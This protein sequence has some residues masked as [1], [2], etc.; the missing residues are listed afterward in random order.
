MFIYFLILLKTWSPTVPNSSTI[1]PLQTGYVDDFG[2]TDRFFSV[3]TFGLDLSIS[4]PRHFQTLTK[5]NAP[6]QMPPNQ[7][8][9]FLDDNYNFIPEKKINFEYNKYITFSPDSMFISPLDISVMK[10]VNINLMNTGTSP[11]R[12]NN[13]WSISKE[14]FIPLYNKITLNEKQATLIPIYICPSS[15]GVFSTLI[16]FNTNK[17]T[18]PYF[19]QYNAVNSNSDTTQK[20]L[21]FQATGFEENV[22]FKIPQ[23]E[24]QVT[25]LYDSFLFNEMRS[26]VN[27]RFVQLS[28][29]KNRVGYYTSFVNVM[30]ENFQRTY[31]FSLVVSQKLLVPVKP[32]LFIETVTAKNESK[33]YEIKI[34]NPTS[35]LIEITSIQPPRRMPDNVK[36]IDYQLPIRCEIHSYTTIGKVIIDG[37]IEGEV[38]TNV[39]L[40][41]MLS[42]AS[43]QSLSIPIRGLVQY[44]RLRPSQEKIQMINKNGKNFEFN[45]TNEFKVPIGILGAR[46]SNPN[47]VVT[48]FAPFALSPGQTSHQLIISKTVI[49]KVQ[50]L[51]TD[52]HIQLDIL[53][54]IT[55]LTIPIYIY[56][57]VVYFSLTNTT[58]P[59]SG[60]TKNQVYI[61]AGKIHI[62][63][64]KK[65]RFYVNN[66]NPEPFVI[67]S[68]QT[69]LE[70][71]ANVSFGDYDHRRV[72]SNPTPPFGT[73]QIELIFNFRGLNRNGQYDTSPRKDTV[74]L[75][76]STSI[77]TIVI[78]WQPVV[79]EIIPRVTFPNP[80]LYGF[81]HYADLYLTTTFN[82]TL[83]LKEIAPSEFNFIID[84][85]DTVILYPGKETFVGKLMIV[86]DIFLLTQSRQLTP[87]GVDPTSTP[88]DI[89]WEII[90]KSPAP[91]SFDMFFSFNESLLF[92]FTFNQFMG[93]V[94]YND[95][96]FQLNDT[97]VSIPTNTT[98]SITNFFDLPIHYSVMPPMFT[99]NFIPLCSELDFTLQ[100]NETKVLKMQYTWSEIG[101]KIVKTRI[102]TN[103]TPPFYQYSI[104][105]VVPP[106]VKF[107]YIDSPSQGDRS[108][109]SSRWS[110]FIHI[111]NEGTTFIQLADIFSLQK[112]IHLN[113]NDTLMYPES[114]FIIE[115]KIDPFRLIFQQPNFTLVLTTFGHSFSFDIAFPLSDNELMKI[116]Y[117]QTFIELVLISLGL[118]PVIIQ[119]HDFIHKFIKSRKAISKKLQPS[120][121]KYVSVGTLVNEELF[122]A[123]SN[124]AKENHGGVF[125]YEKAYVQQ[126]LE[127]FQGYLREVIEKLQE[128]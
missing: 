7:W 110:A 104:A 60:A 122:N 30:G 124:K 24:D 103:A 29:G 111:M 1:V 26:S 45:L 11:I 13:I 109:F 83:E 10:T 98:I 9:H 15:V 87:I 74:R 56:S 127:D 108:I 100:P 97:L 101:I 86:A 32:F 67:Q 64:Y 27:N 35:V 48:N 59:P 12:V 16:F 65:F 94:T 62:S 121:P 23:N 34:M 117:M 37:S 95:Y 77:F 93:V 4:T 17:G 5:D 102:T 118:I 81:K 106:E 72:I 25:L 40:T 79:G 88:T 90:S 18:F 82:E 99:D 43:K 120:T 76:G 115:A 123:I 114:E 22:T 50:A 91:F 3:K 58:Q 78:N 42:D 71:D 69:P 84:C 2:Y 119:L 6:F 85:P 70:I 28:P 55:K 49:S 8:M 21:F 112:S 19:V 20:P 57:G 80:I 51:N 63:S 113:A 89:D 39:S 116:Q 14:I 73:Q 47:F 38:E 68:I 128:K 52:Q 126:S 33:E 105:T 107:L 31:P 54:N 36:I 53:T 61:R 125:V 75:I 66:P 44:G 92:K 46:I 41:Y 96:Y